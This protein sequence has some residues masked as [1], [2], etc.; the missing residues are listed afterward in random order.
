M[1]ILQ[2]DE[3]QVRTWSRARKDRWWFK[4]EYDKG[5][6]VEF[7]KE[8]VRQHYRSTGYFDALENARKARQPEPDIPALP[9]DLVERTSDLYLKAFERITGEKFR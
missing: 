2:L 7:S 3:E 8:F 5:N 1:A 6:F 4:N 9:R